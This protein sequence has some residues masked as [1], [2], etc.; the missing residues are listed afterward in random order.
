MK[1]G[2]MGRSMTRT[3]MNASVGSAQFRAAR[4]SIVAST[5]IERLMKQPSLLQTIGSDLLARGSF[6]RRSK[7]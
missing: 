5:S 3:E 4:I 2:A 7:L 1:I 6:R